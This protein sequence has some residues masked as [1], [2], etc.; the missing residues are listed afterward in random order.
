MQL[1]LLL[2]NPGCLMPMSVVLRCLHLPLLLLVVGVVVVEGV[3]HHVAAALGAGP[4]PA[5]A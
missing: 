3:V 2:T 4:G 5:L 1:G